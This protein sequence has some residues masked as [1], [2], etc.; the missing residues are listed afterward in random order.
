MEQVYKKS[1][2][3]KDLSACSFANLVLIFR[4]CVSI[5]RVLLALLVTALIWASQVASEVSITPK[6]SVWST[7]WRA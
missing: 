4:V 7:S 5:A 6:Y 1:S 3:T 2:L